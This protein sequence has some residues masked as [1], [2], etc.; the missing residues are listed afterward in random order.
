VGGSIGSIHW[1]SAIV[2][3]DRLFMPDES[4]NLYA[5]GLK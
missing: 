2:V 1:E 5:Y 3:N 4:G